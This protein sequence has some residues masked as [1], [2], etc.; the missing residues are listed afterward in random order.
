MKVSVVFPLVSFP[1]FAACSPAVHNTDPLKNINQ[2]EAALHSFLPEQAEGAA[3]VIQKKKPPVPSLSDKATSRASEPKLGPKQQSMNVARQVSESRVVLSDK[4]SSRPSGMGQQSMKADRQAPANR[5][6]LSYSYK[7]DTI[8]G[9]RVEYGP[10]GIPQAQVVY[11]SKLIPIVEKEHQREVGTG[12]EIPVLSSRAPVPKKRAEK[13][14]SPRRSASISAGGTSY[15]AQENNEEYR[16]EDGTGKD[17]STSS[18]LALLQKKRSGTLSSFPLSLSGGDTD[19]RARAKKPDEAT[20]RYLPVQSE[21]ELKEELTAL[22]KTGDWNDDGAGKQSVLASY[23]IQ[24]DIPKSFI[25]PRI[26][27]NMDFLTSLA[28]GKKAVPEEQ[29]DQPEETG[30]GVCD[31]PV[32]VNKQV[33]FYLD[34]FQNQQREIF[35]QWLKRAASYLPSIKK[36]LKKADL[37]ESL[38]YLAMIES[39]FKPDAYSPSHASG[40][41]Q[42]IEGTARHYGLRI[43]SWVD[44]RRDPEKSTR[45]AVSYLNALYKKFGDWHLAV[46][47]YNA[48]EGKVQ[49]GLDNYKVKTFWDLASKDYLALETKRYVPKLIAAVIIA[50]DPKRYGFQPVQE[51]KEQVDVVDVPSGTPLSAV[52]AAGG[53]S[54]KKIRQLNNELLKDQVPP[55][56]GMYSIKVPAGSRIRIAE[57]LERIRADEERKIVH[58]LRAG[59]TLSGIGKRYNVPVDM[60][61]RWND[62]DDVRSIRAGRKLAL[63]LNGKSDIDAVDTGAEAE[64]VRYYKVR[65]GDSLWSIAR[66]HQVSTKQIKRWNG[67]D[68]NLLHPGR[69]LVIKKS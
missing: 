59:E 44:E 26:H 47:A 13:I 27:L 36:E 5:I 8:S 4:Y 29:L 3:E 16:R 38:A 35:R 30:K 24:C 1:L 17:A 21:Q 37:P 39:G 63:Y 14:S 31:F 69:K 55:T 52:A 60:I 46:A 34:Q 61:V 20:P 41:W 32:T 22:E 6:A 19:R 2:E 65:H 53:C 66:K 15:R 23:G 40:L 58:K 51:K 68:N 9:S 43:D 62:I 10:T 18:T 54:V 57:N 64:T 56:K 42:F 7:P 48:G 11:S 12:R 45:A 50:H 49:R 67:L 28:P 25:R 33:K